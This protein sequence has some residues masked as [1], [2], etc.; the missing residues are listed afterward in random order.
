MNTCS[1]RLRDVLYNRTLADDI[2]SVSQLTDAGFRMKFTKY[3]CQI[4]DGND[5]THQL[6]GLLDG[7]NCLLL[8]MVLRSMVLQSACH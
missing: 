5:T 6:Q 4:M 3:C 2:L 8:A 7:S 1:L